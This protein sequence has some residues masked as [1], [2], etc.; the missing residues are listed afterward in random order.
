MSWTE[1]RINKLEKLWSEGFS[2]SRI[3]EQMGGI[4]RSAVLG[5]VH[6]LGLPGRSI[7]TKKPKRAKPKKRAKLAGGIFNPHNQP[8]PKEVLLPALKKETIPEKLISFQ[9]LEE[10]QCKYPYGN[11]KSGKFGYC[12]K[13]V[14]LGKSYCAGCDAKTRVRRG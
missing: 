2:A 13:P 9:D 14:A 11:P 3:A 8:P 4:S 5:K 12:G 7:S 6:R 10:G 1:Q